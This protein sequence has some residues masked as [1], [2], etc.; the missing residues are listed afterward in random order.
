M[1]IQNIADQRGV[2]SVN[3]DC[4]VTYCGPYALNYVTKP[5]LVGIKVG[6]KF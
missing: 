6:E 4:S 5:R 3:T 2:L 1:F